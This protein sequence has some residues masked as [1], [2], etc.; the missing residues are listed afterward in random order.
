MNENEFDRTARAWLEDGPTR[1]SDRAVLSALEEIHTT[2]QRRAWWPARRA[3]PVNIFVRAAIAAVLV[4]GVG[5][6]AINV[7]PRQPDGSGVGGQPTTIPSPSA[8]APPSPA[9]SAQSVVIPDL[10]QTFVSSTNGFSIGY[11]DGA[12]ISPA[13]VVANPFVEQNN[14]EFDFINNEPSHTFRGASSLAPGTASIDDW[15]DRGFQPGGCQ[16]RRSEQAEITID[17][18]PGRIWEGCPNEI[19]ATVAVGRRVYVFSLFG[20]ADVP[21][22]SRAVFDAYASTIDLRPEEAASPAP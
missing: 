11:P 8:S 9:E 19:E 1:M 2:R 12:I 4:V 13:T 14:E 18:Q 15:I 7:L 20:A 22:V 17:G 3:T 6:L 5:L 16:V 10:T 21:D